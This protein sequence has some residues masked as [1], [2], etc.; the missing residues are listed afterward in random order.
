M[1]FGRKAE[2][3][4]SSLIDHSARSAL[5]YEPTAVE[6]REWQGKIES[7]ITVVDAGAIDILTVSILML[8]IFCLD[9]IV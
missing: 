5:A 2:A 9:K 7:V 4:K 3:F 6:T 1:A 8:M